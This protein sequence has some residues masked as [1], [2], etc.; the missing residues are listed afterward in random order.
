MRP[1][2]AGLIS[3]IDKPCLS[4]H[5]QGR[6]LALEVLHARVILMNVEATQ[7]TWQTEKLKF[8]DTIWDSRLFKGLD[9]VDEP[10]SLEFVQYCWN[11]TI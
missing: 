5:Q 3:I 7:S 6:Q 8:P 4:L 10:V 1:L 2:R 11:N 9:D